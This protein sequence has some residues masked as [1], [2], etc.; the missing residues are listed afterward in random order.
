MPTTTSSPPASAPENIKAARAARASFLGSMLEYYDFYIYGAA[1]ALIFGQVFFS[2]ASG[3]MGTLASLAT[4]GVGYVARPIGGIVLGHFG[5]RIGRK[6]IML[7]TLVLMGTSTFIIGCLPSYDSIGIWAP[8]LLVVMRLIGGFSAG[9][10][11]AGANSLTLEHAPANRRAYYC[12]WTLTG[13]QAGFILATGAFL[14]VATLSDEQLY[15]WGWRIPFWASVVV[16]AVAYWVRTRL[17]EP[18]EFQD[19]KEQDATAALPTVVVLKTHGWDVLRVALCAFNSVG[20]SIFAI[21]GLA[22]ATS[23]DIGIAR[24]T[25]LWVAIVANLFALVFQPLLGILADRIGRKPVFITGALGV[26]VSIFIYFAAISTANIA[27]VFV[28]AFLMTSCFYSCLNASWPAMYGE[29]FATPVR[30]SG[31]AIGTQFGIAFAGFAPTIGYAI[32]GDGPRGWVP[33]ALLTAF[34]MVVAAASCATARETY[35][36]PMAE[37]GKPVDHEI[38]AVPTAR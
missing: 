16:V 14:L 22:Y 5:D 6:K 27:L 34:A 9:G 38:D 23:D 25:M 13:T 26:G 4:F 32:L 29:W 7:L 10:E 12:S 28:G 3:V 20:G 30:Y 17:D 31:V 1:A 35:R 24:S 18:E 21:F 37:L 36:T 19:R 2:G 15:S 33:V 11:Q 8:V